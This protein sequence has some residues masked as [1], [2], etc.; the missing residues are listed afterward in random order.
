VQTAAEWSPVTVPSW[1]VATVGGEDEVLAFVERPGFDLPPLGR[2][3]RG[4]VWSDV[5]PDENGG[6]GSFPPAIVY[7]VAAITVER[8]S[9]LVLRADNGITA[10]VDGAPQ[11]A[12]IYG[13]GRMRVPLRL[14]AGENVVVVRLIGG[15]GT[16]TA[17]L[18]STPDEATLN[19]AD[20]TAPDLMVGDTR[21]QY[22][23]LPVL[24]L[25]GRVLRDVR[26]E[27]AG[28]DVF[29]ET[30]LSLPALP[31]GGMTKLA[32]ALQL[33]AAPGEAGSMRPVRLRLASPDLPFRYEQTIELPVVD[34]QATHR[35]SFLSAVDGSAQYFGLVPPSDF[36]PD[37]SYGVV[38]TLHGAGVEGIGQAQAYSA[39]D[40][41]YIAAATNRRPFGFDWEEWGR[42][43]A[44]E[45]LSHTQRVFE[46][47]P[48]R[49]YL[50]GHSMGGHGTWNVG[51]HTPGRFAVVGPS[52]GWSSFYTYTGDAQPTGPFGR[53]RAASNTNDYITNLD[54]RG[55]YVIHG[56][57]D[58][59]VPVREGR[60]MVAL[61]QRT[62][63]DVQ[64]H[65]EP[66][67][68]HWW[69]GERSPGADC[70]D[71]PPLF[72]FMQAHTLDPWELD[73]DFRT[74][75]PSVTP[76]H[77]Y[78][79][80][81]SCLSAD[82]DCVVRSRREADGAVTLTTENVR[83]LVL[84]GAALT[85]LGVT[86]LT[87][88]GETVALAEVD[89]PV[90]PQDGKRPG[91][92]GPV[93]EVY[94]RPF[95]YVYPD[96]AADYEQYA[97][98]QLSYWA[99]IGNGRACALPRSLLTPLVRAEYNLVHLGPEPGD[100]PAVPEGLTWS[101]GDVT[102]GGTTHS[103]ASL[104]YV[105]PDGERLSA[106]MTAPAR[107]VPSLFAVQP[108]SS[109]G[110]LPDYLVF[111]SGRGLAAGFFSPTWGL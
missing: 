20:L 55:I 31:P 103:R 10:Y 68:G 105:Y 21:P 75:S 19:L 17:A 95:C 87:V 18:W 23:G 53:A 110:G 83:G 45:V 48:T 63:D 39:K 92:N 30:S 62:N 11:P 40:W 71:W 46:T 69:D 42:L 34:P 27:V 101:G 15:R 56:S 91:L 76:T 88:D 33:K 37:R 86:G 7:A 26:A 89:L 9:T 64:Y 4:M 78:V 51:V 8:D 47:D 29:Q 99:I 65:E 72:E 111:S 24:N 16:P 49:V 6:L 74:P 3:F 36:R 90:G 79:T 44:L 67:A 85:T 43:D 41:T 108:F 84:D 32:F 59:N 98:H 109:R 77:S 28:D 94:R 61:A 52:A 97:A 100:L 12:D 93:N 25:S 57:A 96:G 66:G 81:R 80:I 35:E 104:V 70:V 22:V 54:R 13:S 82:A 14:K 2:D 73:F 102:I 58:D 38:L 1:R 106:V 107:G 60:D 5:T 50:T